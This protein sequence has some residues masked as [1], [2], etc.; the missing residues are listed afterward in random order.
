M[1]KM[2]Y[3]KQAEILF[4]QDNLSIDKISKRLGISRRTIFY[5]KEKFEWDRK[6]S[7]MI[8]D[9]EGLAKNLRDFVDKLMEK[10]AS[11]MQAK[12]PVNQ[13]E[14]YSLINLLKYLP[15]AQKYDLAINASLE[16]PTKKEITPETIRMIER[17]ILGIKYE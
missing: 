16:S 2:K 5:W 14:F 8:A 4:L 10:L 15:E 1:S 6:K 11:D 12:K 7:E 17:E 9:K 13:S 3:Y